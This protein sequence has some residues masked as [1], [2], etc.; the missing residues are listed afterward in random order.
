MEDLDSALYWFI[1]IAILAALLKG[2]F[3]V[4]FFSGM[5]RSFSS[6]AQLNPFLALFGIRPAPVDAAVLDSRHR[7]RYAFSGLV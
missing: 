4:L 1:G 7:S 2:L 3:W 6:A 5:A